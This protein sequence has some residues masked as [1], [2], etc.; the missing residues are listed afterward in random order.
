MLQ[1]W[2]VN[3]HRRPSFSEIIKQLESIL[4]GIEELTKAPPPPPVAKP[5]PALSI[6]SPEPAHSQPTSADRLTYIRSGPNSSPGIPSTSPPNDDVRRTV[7]ASSI[8]TPTTSRILVSSA[9]TPPLYSPSSSTVVG[10]HSTTRYCVSS[11]W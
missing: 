4:H 2:D 6:T 3:P 8:S 9:H 11:L 7:S 1:C 10:M 5:L